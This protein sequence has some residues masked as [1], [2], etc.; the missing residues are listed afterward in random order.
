MS[1]FFSGPFCGEKQLACCHQ[2]NNAD[3][4]C[5]PD[6]YGLAIDGVKAEQ[7]QQGNACDQDDND[8]LT[9]ESRLL[10]VQNVSPCGSCHTRDLLSLKMIIV[11]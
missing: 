2:V 4:N 1:G 11:A 7:T 6:W 9:E 8:V 3:K 10:T 5:L